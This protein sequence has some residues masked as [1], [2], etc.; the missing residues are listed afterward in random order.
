MSGASEAGARRIVAA[1][2][3]PVGGVREEEVAIGPIRSGQSEGG[4][5]QFRCARPFGPAMLA[6][7][8]AAPGAAGAVSPS[9]PRPC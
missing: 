7:S 8:R 6:H 9:H 1:L 2:R 5:W 4:C 3:G